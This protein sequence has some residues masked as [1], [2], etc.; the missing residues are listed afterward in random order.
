M[1]LSIILINIFININSHLIM[2]DKIFVLNAIMLMF[3]LV[4]I[5]LYAIVNVLELYLTK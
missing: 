4:C 5:V 3:Y 2:N 1:I